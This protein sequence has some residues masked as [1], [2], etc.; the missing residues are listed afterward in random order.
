MSEQCGRNSPGYRPPPPSN[1]AFIPEPQK[2][3]H[4]LESVQVLL[5]EVQRLVQMTYECIR[6]FQMRVAFGNVNFPDLGKQ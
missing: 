1:S 2:K 5:H 3:P 4:H 6:P